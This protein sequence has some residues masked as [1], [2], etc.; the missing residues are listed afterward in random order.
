MVNAAQRKGQEV[1]TTKKCKII[2]VE[3]HEQTCTI[4]NTNSSHVSLLLLHSAI[5][6]E[7][8]Y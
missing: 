5:F 1:D 2:F 6:D 4:T 7:S 8:K 3:V